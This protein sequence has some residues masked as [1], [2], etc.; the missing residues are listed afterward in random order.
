MIKCEKMVKVFNYNF[1]KLMMISRD[2][3]KYGSLQLLQKNIVIISMFVANVKLLTS[4]FE[5]L[6]FK[7]VFFTE[8]SLERMIIGS[9]D[10]LLTFVPTSMLLFFDRK[11]F[12]G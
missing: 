12:L 1:L 6:V 9:C 10:Y 3:G 2:K 5:T 11:M 8:E 7:N 4:L